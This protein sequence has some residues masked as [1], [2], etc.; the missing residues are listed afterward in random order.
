MSLDWYSGAD[1]IIAGSDK[2]SIRKYDIS[3]GRCIARMTVDKINKQDSIVWSVKF[4][5]YNIL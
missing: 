2:S 1:H 3:L 5:R 4:L